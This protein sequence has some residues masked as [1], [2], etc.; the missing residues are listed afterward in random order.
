MATSERSASTAEIMITAIAAMLQDLG[1]VAVGARSPIPGSA[2]H[3]ARIRSGGRLRI[4]I[5]GSREHAPF[6]DGGRELFDCA[7][8]GR[9]DAFFLSG[10]QIDGG[11]NVNLVGVGDVA[12][13]PRSAGA[14]PRLVRFSLPLFR[15][16]ARDPLPSRAHPA[17]AGAQGRLRQRARHEPARRVP[18]RRPLCVGDE[19]RCVPVR[20]STSTVLALQHASGRHA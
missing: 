18:A 7:G 1:H 15:G 8:Q 6:T 9:I 16:A 11:A 5:L 4:S 19:P 12:H 2:A 17:H 14:V 10:G 20:P 13:Y 3:L